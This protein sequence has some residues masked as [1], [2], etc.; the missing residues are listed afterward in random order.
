[1][2]DLIITGEL[3]EENAGDVE[4][5][6]I[7]AGKLL[8]KRAL[9]RPIVTHRPYRDDISDTST[10]NDIFF[11][12]GNTDDEIS[13]GGRTL[14][15]EPWYKKPSI[16]LLLPMFLLLSMSQGAI[17]APRIN[18]LLSLICRA[19]CV[20]QCDNTT[21]IILDSNDRDCQDAEI[22]AMF[23]KFSMWCSVL[24]GIL[25]TI[26][27]AK[28]G[29]LSDRIGR[30]PVLAFC[31]L[32]SMLSYTI[33]ILAAKSTNIY[34]YKWFLLAHFVEGACGGIPAVMSTAHAYATD[35]TPPEKRAAAFGLFHACLLTGIAI[36]P[37]LGGYLVNTTNN[38]LAVF[39]LSIC[40]SIIF[41]FSMMFFLPESLPRHRLLGNNGI[42]DLGSL[43]TLERGLSFQ[44]FVRKLNFIQPLSALTDPD[45]SGRDSKRNV[46][47]I[48]ATDTITIALSAGSTLIMLLYSEYVFGWSSVETGYLIS[49]ICSIRAFVLIVLLP[50][51][52]RFLKKV[53]RET[54]THAYGA[55]RSDLF[56]I[57]VGLICEVLAF[58]GLIFSNTG[59][60]FVLCA[61]VGALGSISSPVLQS[62]LT[63]HISKER[64]GAVLGALSL[65]H[66]IGQIVSPFIFN[67]VFAYTIVI[68]P[69]AS[70]IMVFFIFL[71]CFVI[72]MA[73]RKTSS[74]FAGNEDE[75][76]LEESTSQYHDDVELRTS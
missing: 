61:S 8:S 48:A 46:I 58:L 56:L 49:I 59:A 33:I 69:K 40:L 71:G 41:V 29:A 25:S 60:G 24:Q 32:G 10:S 35:C 37:A 4:D 31:A 16:H 68:Y 76:A 23:S 66:S 63:K 51:V 39:Y 18:L 30:R 70:L 52:V 34:G 38:I 36:G 62:A 12:S 64:T 65:L 13:I 11:F 1:M 74:N 75:F 26:V 28:L 67:S 57:R 72:S 20:G 7:Q 5:E 50:V 53:Y 42:H 14:S 15:G 43:F 6:L 22:Y 54:D 19:R 55:T 45:I 2:S 21:S 27:S 73:L 9:K 17:I 47:L 44:A 3:L